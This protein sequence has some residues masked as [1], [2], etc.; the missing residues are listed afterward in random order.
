MGKFKFKEFETEADLV[1]YVEQDGY[2]WDSD[3]PAICLAFQVHENDA[4]NKY[5]LE[6]Y[7]RD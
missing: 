3:K 1:D 2:G 4:K 6:L 5:E 7:F